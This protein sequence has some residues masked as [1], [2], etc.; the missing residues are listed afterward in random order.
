MDAP[1]FKL[2][3]EQFKYNK[4]KLFFSISDFINLSNT[5]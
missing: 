5:P 4:S 3:S 1:I 2:E